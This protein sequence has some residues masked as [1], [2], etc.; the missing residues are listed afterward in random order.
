VYDTGEHSTFDNGLRHDRI[1]MTL[2]ECYS[3]N[4]MH[5]CS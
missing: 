2:Y 3:D 4:P 1:I 5:S